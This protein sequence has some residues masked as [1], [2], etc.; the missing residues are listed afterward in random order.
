MVI[1]AYEVVTCKPEEDLRKIPGIIFE[2]SVKA[3]A[4]LLHRALRTHLN[5]SVMALHQGKILSGKR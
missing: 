5:L 3:T 2:I 1:G 4:K